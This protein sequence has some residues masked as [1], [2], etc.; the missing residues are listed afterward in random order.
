MPNALPSICPR[1]LEQNWLSW[2]PGIA[3]AKARSSRSRCAIS[4]GESVPRPLERS[5]AIAGPVCA[6][7]R[8]ELQQDGS[9]SLNRNRPDFG[10]L[11]ELRDDRVARVTDPIGCVVSDDR[12]FEKHCDV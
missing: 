1:T 5:C 6:A 2:L 11:K 8:M 7:T 9:R 12:T 3:S 4:S 10:S